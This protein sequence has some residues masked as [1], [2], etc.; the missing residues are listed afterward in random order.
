MICPKC[1]HNN[2]EGAS[3]CVNCGTRLQE[4]GAPSS[5]DKQEASGEAKKEST[6]KWIIPVIIGAAV[7]VFLIAG[8]IAAVAVVGYKKYAANREETAREEQYTGDEDES[9]DTQ[10]EEVEPEEA[11]SK[12][13]KK[14]LDI[15]ALDRSSIVDKNAEQYYDESLVPSVPEY[16]VKPDLSNLINPDDFDH[17]SP[18]AKKKLAENHFVVLSGGLE[19][20]DIYETN[21]YGQTPSFVT[22]DSMMHTYHLYFAHLLKKIEKE[23]LYDELRELSGEMYDESV[24]QYRELEGTEWERAALRNVAFFTV[25]SR[26]LEIRRR[27]FSETILSTV[28]VS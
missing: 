3:F 16:K 10:E 14:S 26:L 24:D 22:V 18:D 21:R 11:G 8:I 1:N 4:Q 9:Y 17:M 5:T 19:F 20:F 7:F 13:K 27:Y 28:I 2:E 6:N 23:E 25:G 12:K 15:K